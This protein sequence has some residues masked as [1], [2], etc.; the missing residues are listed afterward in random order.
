MD[1][2]LLPTLLVHRSE[3]A[4]REGDIDLKLVVLKRLMKFFFLA[5]HVQYARYLSQYLLDVRAE[6]A[7]YKVDLVCRQGDGFWNSVSADQ[8][9]EQTAIR[10]GKGGLKGLTLLPD[11]FR[12][13]IESFPIAVHV[14]DSVESMYTDHTQS[15]NT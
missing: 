7:T 2:F 14:S 4:E 1:N 9:G 15:K 8:F 11:L 12:E 6:P 3:Q 10:I 13:W 5:V